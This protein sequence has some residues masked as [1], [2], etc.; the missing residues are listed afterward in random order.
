MPEIRCKGCQGV[1]YNKPEPFIKMP[2]KCPKCGSMEFYIPSEEDLER[3]RL[4][5]LEASGRLISSLLE[6]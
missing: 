3:E 1:V 6:E 2:K 4:Q 5:A